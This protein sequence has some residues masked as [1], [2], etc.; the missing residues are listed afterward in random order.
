[1]PRITKA[2]LEVW[3]SAEAAAREAERQLSSAWES[4][5]RGH[6]PPPPGLL[7]TEVKRLRGIANERLA[8]ALRVLSEHSAAAKPE[9]RHVDQ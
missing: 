6:L 1:V 9:S 2:A 7:F 4:Y 5:E 8:A 3:R